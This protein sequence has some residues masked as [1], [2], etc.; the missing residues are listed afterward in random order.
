MTHKNQPHQRHADSAAAS[1]PPHTGTNKETPRLRVSPVIRG[2]AWF[3]ADHRP[4]VLRVE[5]PLSA[6]EMIAA[7]YGTASPQDISTAEGLYGAVAVTLSIEGLPGLIA[8][9]EKIRF[10]ERRGIV[11]SIAF[12][13]QCR[14]R[15]TALL[16]QG[17]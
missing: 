10:Q 5:Y 12:L 4:F 13:A 17:R 11:E 7:L 6:E 15:V 8:R 2:D 9:A 14:E 16:D 3:D 1:W